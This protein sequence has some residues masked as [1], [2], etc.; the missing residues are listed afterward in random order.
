[1]FASSGLN[2]GFIIK[3]KENSLS[4]QPQSHLTPSRTS[5]NGEV[6]SA[7]NLI[8]FRCLHIALAL[9]TKFVICFDTDKT[10]LASRARE[11][12]VRNFVIQFKSFTSI[13][14]R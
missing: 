12:L 7:E 3:V 9:L 8:S 4:C 14:R 1:M 13:F 11:S 2:F 5:G 6:S 10:V